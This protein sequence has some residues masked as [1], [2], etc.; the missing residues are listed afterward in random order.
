MCLYVTNKI[1]LWNAF[2]DQ[3]I[4]T[5]TTAT[6][7][8]Y[9]KITTNEI[10]KTLQRQILYHIITKSQTLKFFYWRLKNNNSSNNNNNNNAVPCIRP[11]RRWACS[12]WRWTRRRCRRAAWARGRSSGRCCR[13]RP[14]S[15]CRCR[16]SSGELPRSANG[17]TSSGLVRPSR[18]WSV[19]KEVQSQ[20]LFFFKSKTTKHLY[21]QIYR[22]H[23]FDGKWLNKLKTGPD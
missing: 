1:S 16:W 5:R 13:T 21:W 22:F 10:L 8:L 3:I 12:S 18:R 20:I 6:T 2:C 4:I 11:F 23:F 15:W 17:G 9:N 7:I 19:R 14:R